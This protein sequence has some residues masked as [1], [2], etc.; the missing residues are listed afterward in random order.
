MLSIRSPWHLAFVA[1]CAAVILWQCLLGRPGCAYSML[2]L[3]LWLGALA[4]RWL[5][6]PDRKSTHA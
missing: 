4:Y 3:S 6:R 5:R 2:V 1:T